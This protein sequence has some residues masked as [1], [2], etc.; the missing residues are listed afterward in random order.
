MFREFTI[1]LVAILQYN[2]KSSELT[3]HKEAPLDLIIFMILLLME[4]VVS[5]N[6]SY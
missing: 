2:R 1:F 6:F 4:V 3:K 5:Y